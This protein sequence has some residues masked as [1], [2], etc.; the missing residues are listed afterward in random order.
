MKPT[1]NSSRGSAL[2]P[3]LFVALALLYVWVVQPTD[4][5]W[6]RVPVMTVIVLIPFV[7]AFRHGDSLGE[8]GLRIDN[9]GAS[10][11]QVGA[12]TA[13]G[14]IVVVAIGLLAGHAPES[15][16]G[17]VR[18]ILLYPFWGLAQQ[19][20]MQS[21]TFRRIRESVGSP[22]AA[23]SMAAVL[24]GAVHWPNLPLALVTAIG[25]VVWCLLFH[26]TPNLITLA[27]SHGW[28]AVLLRAAWP[29]EWL[30]N[31]RIGPSYWTWTP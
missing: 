1:R 6:I 20:A 26:R 2:E 16:P 11:A 31:L 24:F 30:H 22:V 28:L 18:A 12:A 9:I 17:I 27:L 23:A 8:L 7:S 13:A 21:F 3:L 15:R 5:D 25:G 14:A 29:A 10:A 4:N 19:Y